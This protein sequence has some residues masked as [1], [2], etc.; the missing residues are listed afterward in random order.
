MAW[1]IPGIFSD[2]IQGDREGNRSLKTTSVISDFSGS[3]PMS[4]IFGDFTVAERE[5]GINV[6]FQYGVSER[7]VVSDQSGT[8]L[9]SSISESRAQVSTGTGVGSA[10]MQSID[11]IRYITGREIVSFFTSNFSAPE[12]DTYQW[13]G[14]LDETNGFAIGHNSEGFGFLFRRAGVDSI[15]LQGDEDTTTRSNVKP[16]WFDFD[17]QSLRI[18][19]IS[20]GWLGAAPAV[21][22]VYGGYGVGWVPLHVIDYSGQ[23]APHLINPT[24]PIRAEVGRTA[25]TGSDVSIKTSSWVGSTVGSLPAGTGADRTFQQFVRDKA[26]AGSNNPAIPRPV[27]SIRN[28]TTFKGITNHVLARYGTVT[29]ATD[30]NKDV[31]ITIYRNG[32]LTGDS[33]TDIDTDNSTCEFDVSATAY[34]PGLDNEPIGGTIMGKTDKVRINLFEDDVT[35]PIRPGEVVTLCADSSQASEISVFLRHIEEF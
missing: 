15:M 2:L 24:L 17:P 9:V 29:I 22:S 25:G 34:D 16:D 8:G 20:Y 19:K 31:F 7:D 13:H 35:I 30:G 12:N 14:V 3:S 10:S 4:T 27:I 28:K 5:N 21:F 23:Q 33:F 6:Q 32:T 1:T 18:Y 26:I 11:A